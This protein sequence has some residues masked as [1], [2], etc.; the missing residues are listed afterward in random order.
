MRTDEQTRTAVNEVLIK[1]A[2]AMETKDID[3]FMKLFSKD[4]NMLT[5]GPEEAEMSIGPGQLK[6]RMEKTFSEAET[7]SLKYGWTS[8]KANGP[9]AWVASHVY[10][11]I[12]K[13]GQE[14]ISLSARLTGV[15]EKID[16]QWL[17]TQQH[18]SV[19]RNIEEGIAKALKLLEAER[20]K[21]AEAEAEQAKA[22]AS[23]EEPAKAEQAEDEQAEVKQAEAAEK[24]PAEAKPPPKEKPI[25]EDI[26]Y[27]LE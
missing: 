27:E 8:I 9:A 25:D 3:V 12:K 16:N 21:A 24:P 7:L 23:P 2:Q 19:A 5:I 4:S 17:W 13:K 11:N 20:A 26:F 14:E 1:M 22:A 10:Y 18:L 6:E 15:L